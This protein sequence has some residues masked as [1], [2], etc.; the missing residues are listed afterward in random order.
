MGLTDQP[1]ARLAKLAK[2]WL[3]APELKVGRGGC[4]SEGYDPTQ[5]AYVLECKRPGQPSVTDIEL[6]GNPYRPVVNPCL[7]FHNW[8]DAEVTLKANG[9]EVPRGKDFPFGQRDSLEGRDLIVW[10]KVESTT[11]ARMQ[12]APVPKRASK[13]LL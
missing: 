12:L 5:R 9:Q 11:S 8:G 1:A 2:S 7:V 6:D 10:V 4:S 3:Y 13:A